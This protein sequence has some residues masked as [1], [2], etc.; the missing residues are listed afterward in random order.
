MS[1]W[2]KLL[3]G[4]GIGCFVLV[5]LLI[6]GC[7][8]VWYKVGRPVVEHAQR[9]EAATTETRRR[10]AEVEKLDASFPPRL[11]EDPA[12]AAIADDDINRYLRIRNDL[13][14]PLAEIEEALLR[15]IPS[16]EEIE[17]NPFSGALKMAGGVMSGLADAQAARGRLLEAARASLE[18]EGTGPT[19]FSRM[20]ALVEWRFLRREEA[21]PA[22]LAP[23][24]RN[25]ALQHIAEIRVVEPW[26]HAKMPP[27]M[28][29]QGRDRADMQKE[30]DQAKAALVSLRAEAEAQVGMTET[31]RAALE[32][33]RAELEALPVAGLLMLT[34]PLQE[35]P[36]FLN[37]VQS[38][39]RHDRP[40]EPEVT[41]EVAEEPGEI[42]AEH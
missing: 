3:I 25:E 40:E 21:M 22:G 31:T 8:V 42:E 7:A 41:P 17:K 5:A 11:P 1:P 6:T 34:M 14:V 12:V 27:S 10:S 2:L 39:Q 28:Q 37:E 24:K 9:M 33:R 30:V 23:E 19:D 38:R 29:I 16:P 4:C 15:A 18:R 35:E 36:A 13:A 20:V 32:A 26:I